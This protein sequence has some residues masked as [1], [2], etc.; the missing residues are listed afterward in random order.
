MYDYFDVQR[1]SYL[2]FGWPQ[3]RAKQIGQTGGVAR[4]GVGFLPPTAMVDWYSTFYRGEETIDGRKLRAYCRAMEAHFAEA[5]RVVRSGGTIAYAV[6]N[7]TRLAR[8]FDLV[9][10]VVELM[11]RAGF[12]AVVPYARRQTARRI[13]PAGRHPTT[14]R[15]STRHERMVDERIIYGHRP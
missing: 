6:A 9:D 13:L 2:A 11:R 14:G 4:D 10:A 3:E 7:S 1:L 15:F 5:F 12:T 8:T